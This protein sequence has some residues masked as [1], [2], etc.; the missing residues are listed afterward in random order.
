MQFLLN[1]KDEFSAA[2]LKKYKLAMIQKSS[3]F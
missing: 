3:D 1:R 2:G